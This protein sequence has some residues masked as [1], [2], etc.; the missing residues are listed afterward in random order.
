[1]NKLL[2]INIKLMLIKNIKFFLKLISLYNQIIYN[3]FKIYYY[4]FT[5]KYI[6]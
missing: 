5:N 6:Y 4:K 1:M 3:N 2:L